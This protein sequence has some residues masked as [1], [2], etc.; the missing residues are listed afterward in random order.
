MIVDY[1]A[2]PILGDS[3]CLK[4]GLVKRLSDVD[5]SNLNNIARPADQF[6]EEKSVNVFNKK[7]NEHVNF[8]KET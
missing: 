5:K 7:F 4:F 3:S 1:D 8:E 2:P 6:K